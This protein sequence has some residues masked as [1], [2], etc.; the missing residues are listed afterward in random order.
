VR[1]LFEKTSL[2]SS[3]LYCIVIPYTCC[4]VFYW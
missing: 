4:S 1:D 2:L 3:Q